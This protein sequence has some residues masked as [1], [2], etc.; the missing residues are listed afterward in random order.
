MNFVL[1]MFA[2]GITG[3]IISG[4]SGALFGVIAGFSVSAWEE[5]TGGVDDGYS[6]S[7][8][9]SPVIASF[10]DD[11]NWL[12]TVFGGLNSWEENSFSSGPEINPATG[13][14]MTGDGIGGFDAGGNPYGVDWSNNDLDMNSFNF[15]DDIFSTSSD[16]F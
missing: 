3:L 12:G 4:P 1:L 8:C 5:L 10:D 7:S 6:A 16:P 13:L 15:S 2:G 14:L 11:H 9:K